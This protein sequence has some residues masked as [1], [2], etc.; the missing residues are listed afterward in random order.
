MRRHKVFLR[1]I[2]IALLSDGLSCPHDI[3]AKVFVV[4]LASLFDHHHGVLKVQVLV[5]KVMDHILL[6]RQRPWIVQASNELRPRWPT[7]QVFAIISLSLYR[8]LKVGL[9]V[10]GGTLLGDEGE[11]DYV[12]SEDLDVW[13]WSSFTWN[14]D[15]RPLQ[16]YIGHIILL[17]TRFDLFER[18]KYSQIIVLPLFLVF[19]SD[20][21]IQRWLHSVQVDLATYW[22]ASAKNELLLRAFLEL[23]VK[24][25]IV[26]HFADV[27]KLQSDLVSDFFKLSLE[28]EIWIL[29]HKFLHFGAHI[30]GWIMLSILC[31]ILCRQ[32]S[33][34]ILNV[35]LLG[36]V[37]FIV[38]ELLL[39]ISG[40][41]VHRLFH[42]F[43][44]LLVDSEVILFLCRAEAHAELVKSL[45]LQGFIF[46]AITLSSE[47]FYALLLIH[48]VLRS[49]V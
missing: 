13:L 16:R 22:D 4:L 44:L 34:Q 26:D 36:Q 43:L 15:V 30:C 45:A 25:T 19:K 9:Q 29:L 32:V 49:P 5:D 35:S 18:S 46:D 6:L 7:V 38:I 2:H 37:R 47:P 33:D 20:P 8:V 41:L 40:K 28:I 39:H 11:V 12:G 48:I 23:N 17:L 14:V 1:T 3:H 27:E 42:L 24:V 10:Y 31:Q 21:E